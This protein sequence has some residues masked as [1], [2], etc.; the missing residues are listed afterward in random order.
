MPSQLDRRDFL[1]AVS[2]GAAALGQPFLQTWNAHGQGAEST[3]VVQI[4]ISSNYATGRWYFDPV[5]VYL[6][7]GQKV[8]WVC[9]TIGASATAFH[10]A[11]GNHELRIPE[12]A[13]PFDSGF[14]RD[15]EMEGSSFE[16]VFDV[17]GTYDYF[18]RNHERLGAVA[19]IIVGV[20]GGPGER[21]LGY[22]GSEGRSPIFPDV[23]K[24]HS[25]IDS[26]RIVHEKLVKYPAALMERKFPER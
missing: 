24:L 13:K 2:L 10:P 1:K 18:S 4:R 3:D 21:P 12:N 20:P 19:R 9:G 11:N 26:E 15:R 8:K 25:W 6:K 5:G 17:E 23:R 7:P 14:L 22:G 16:W